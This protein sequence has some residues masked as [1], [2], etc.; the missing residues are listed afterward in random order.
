R[1]VLDALD[2]IEEKQ[3]DF[4][5]Q[6]F[7]SNYYNYYLKSLPKTTEPLDNEILQDKI[8]KIDSIIKNLDYIIDN[9]SPLNTPLEKLKNTE[10]EIIKLISDIN[11][12]A[13]N[14]LLTVKQLNFLSYKM[15]DLERMLSKIRNLINDFNHS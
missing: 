9:Y 6:D 1:D 14:K 13:N 2:R 10:N 8:F 4:N 3:N 15:S 7:K 11:K 5:K 12:L